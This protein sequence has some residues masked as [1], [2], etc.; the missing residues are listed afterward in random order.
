M[1]TA[2]IAIKSAHEIPSTS[3]VP[4]TPLSS[5]THS[6]IIT[7]IFWVGEAASGDNGYIANTASTWDSAWEQHFGGLDDPVHRI[8]FRTAAFIPKENSFY[9]ALPYSDINNSGNRKPSAT[10]CPFSQ[11]LRGQDILWCKNCWIAI[12]HNGKVAYAQWEDAGPFGEDDAAYVFGSA[13]PTNNRGAKAGLDVSPAV[14][15]YL[16]LQDVARCDWAFVPA[17]SIPEGPWR[18]TITTTVGDSLD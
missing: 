11:P 8:G 12:R 10:M 13:Y 14:R 6:S 5:F 16:G 7:T 17:Q 3:P 4:F 15:D 9:V 18:Q 2:D 1:P